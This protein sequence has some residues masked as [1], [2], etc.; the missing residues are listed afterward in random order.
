MTARP[1]KSRIL[2][3]TVFPKSNKGNTVG[4]KNKH[5]TEYKDKIKY[6]EHKNDVYLNKKN[7]INYIEYV[8][9]D[10]GLKEKH[11][12]QLFRIIATISNI[13]KKVDFSKINAEI[14]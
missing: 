11:T 5:K 2:G 14:S 13:D 4:S 12:E 9:E 8:I 6:I 1:R 7:L 10:S 3:K